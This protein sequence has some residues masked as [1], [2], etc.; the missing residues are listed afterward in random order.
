MSPRGRAALFAAGAFVCAVLAA[1]AGGGDTS[2]TAGLG[3]LRS[4]AVVRNDLGGGTRIGPAQVRDAF[5]V[6]RVPTEFAPPDALASAATAVGDRLATDL[7]AGSYLTSSALRP[8]G[9]AGRTR[10][11][12]PAGTTPVEV[13]VAAAGALAS[14]SG[15]AARVDVVVA[16][17]PTPGPG[18]GRTYVAAERVPLLALSELPPEPGV[19][20]RWSATLAL[21]RPQALEL[22]RAEGLGRTIRLLGR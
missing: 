14:A 7:P 5:E 16:S 1:A 21:T 19:P 15:G 12:G 11:R 22:I 9:D 20:E 13:P 17:T 8:A 3:D 18:S 10:V 2:A 4:V 6:K